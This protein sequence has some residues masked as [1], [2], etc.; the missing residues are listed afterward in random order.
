MTG[1]E[2][3]NVYHSTENTVFTDMSF[4]PDYTGTLLGTFTSAQDYDDDIE[5]TFEIQC[6][7]TDDTIETTM[8]LCNNTYVSGVACGSSGVMTVDLSAYVEE[9]STLNV[10]E[11]VVG[12]DVRAS[13][14]NGDLC[15]KTSQLKS[16]YEN[17]EADPISAAEHVV[18]AIVIIGLAVFA[19]KRLVK[20][21][22]HRRGSTNCQCEMCKKGREGDHY[23]GGAIV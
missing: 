20:E 19:G 15:L 14:P 1:F 4:R 10:M 3:S 23:Q 7:T 16:V 18:A 11:G 9:Y 17:L 12:C 21:V 22:R 6:P 5:L 8:D 2:C 13:A